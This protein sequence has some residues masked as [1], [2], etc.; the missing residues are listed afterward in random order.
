[1]SNFITDAIGSFAGSIEYAF[2]GGAAL[3]SQSDSL[4]AQLNALNQADYSPGGSI[5]NSIAAVNGTAAADAALKQVQDNAA[6]SAAN[7]TVKD[8]LQTAGKEGAA[9]GLNSLAAGIQN[10]TSGLL[11]TLTKLVPWQAWLAL[12]IGAFLYFGGLKWLKKSLA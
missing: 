11:S 3:Q 7:G 9:Q 1:M 6:S 5:Y 10:F 12:A 8:Q 4:D 2:G